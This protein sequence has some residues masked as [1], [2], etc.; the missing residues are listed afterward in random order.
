MMDLVSWLAPGVCLVAG[1]VGGRLVGSKRSDELTSSS[2]ASSR[3]HSTQDSEA[4]ARADGRVAEL[5]TTLELLRTA[6]L[7]AAA[8]PREISER[9]SPSARELDGL[10][11]ALRGFAFV[12]EAVVADPHGFVWSRGET[13]AGRRLAAMTPLLAALARTLGQQGAEVASLSYSTAGAEHVTARPLPGWT[14]DAWLLAR[15]KSHAPSAL[16][17][18]AVIARAALSRQSR[19]ASEP[20]RAAAQLRGTTGRAGENG[21]RAH[22]VIDELA[23]L[24]VSRAA[25][26]LAFTYAGRPLVTLLEDGPPAA[27]VEI[28][29]ARLHRF[30]RQ[31]TRAAGESVVQVGITLRGGGRLDFAP[32]TDESNCALLAL[33]AYPLEPLDVERFTG[34]VRRLVAQGGDFAPRQLVGGEALAAS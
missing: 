28:L 29:V 32:L 15:S 17:L 31:L 13:I 21:A 30:H 23:R 6:N 2:R 26:A 5:S 10:A 16:A 3:E 9:S 1:V 20:R 8:P 34:R 27:V 33:G 18:D 14:G 19:A 12:D 7:V 25:S 24:S 11:S 22:T 4:R